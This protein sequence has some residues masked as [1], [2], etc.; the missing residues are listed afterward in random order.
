MVSRARVISS[1]TATHRNIGYG[2]I[3]AL[4][5]IALAPRVGAQPTPRPARV[6]AHLTVDADEECATAAAVAARVHQRSRRIEFVSQPNG[7]PSLRVAIRA[8]SAGDRVAELAVQWPDGRRSERQLSARGCAAALDAL[9]LLVAMALDPAALGEDGKTVGAAGRGAGRGKGGATGKQSGGV[10]PEEGQGPSP[11]P[12]PSPSPD[13]I[14]IPTP[15]PGPGSEPEP[16]PEPEPE[17]E[18][19]SESDAEPGSGSDAESDADRRRGHGGPKFLGLAHVAVGASVQLSTGLAPRVMPGVGLYALL[20]LN[21]D[22]PWAPA[23]ELQVAHAWAYG[24]RQPDG[25]AD[26]ELQSARLEA[27]PLGLQLSPLTA[28][29]CVAGAIGRVVAAGSDSYS[30][31]SHA[32]LWASLG[33]SVLV[34]IGLG[35]LLEVQA[36]FGADRPLRRYDFAFRPDVFHRV[37][38][39]CFQGHLGA[40]VRFP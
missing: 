5:T 4:A 15:G 7:I 18:S 13:P 33:G 27:C 9:A 31:Q 29:A 23:V 38:G 21:G 6:Q 24:L 35:D 3:A 28:R 16:G 1:R 30:P 17:S 40:G 36:G 20:A 14:P 19:E 22:G 11:D 32:E 25:N 34:T 8:G 37:P 26:F 39:L 2:V 10:R 12:S